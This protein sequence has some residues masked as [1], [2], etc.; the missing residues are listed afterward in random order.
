MKIEFVSKNYNDSER[1]VRIVE[2]KLESLCK[3]LPDEVNSIVKL[4]AFGKDGEQM[5]YTMGVL[6]KF[7]GKVIRSEVT[8]FNMWDNIDIIMPKLESQL[9]K[10]KDK[11]IGG[12]VKGINSFEEND[13]EPKNGALSQPKDIGK[14]VKIKNF[15]ISIITVEQAIEE[16]ELLDHDFFVFVNAEDNKVS[17]LYKRQDGNYGLISPEY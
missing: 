1:L 9:S 5:K 7:R 4:K 3:F 8:S 14:I 15:Q 11:R 12:S 6:I 13:E 17:V 10:I 2:T 16:I